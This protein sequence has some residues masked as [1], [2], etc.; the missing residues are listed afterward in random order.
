MGKG[1]VQVFLV[2]PTSTEHVDERPQ[3]LI[4]GTASDV[5]AKL[6]SEIS[7]EP[8]TA[9]QAHALKGVEIEDAT[10]EP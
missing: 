1:K 3:R 4:R 7:V 6:R 8:C 9:E 5:R 2:T 10:Q